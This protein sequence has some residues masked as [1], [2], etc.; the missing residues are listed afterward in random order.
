M[1]CKFIRFEREAQWRSCENRKANMNVPLLKFDIWWP[2]IC[3]ITR[4]FTSLFLMI[5][6][7]AS[8]AMGV[9]RIRSWQNFKCSL[10]EHWKTRAW[11]TSV[12]MYA[13]F[14]WFL[15]IFIAIN[16]SWKGFS[17]EGILESSSSVASQSSVCS[18][19]VGK[20]HTSVKWVIWR[21]QWNV[22]VLVLWYPDSLTAD[23]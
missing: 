10:N 14:L 4:T 18:P 6:I 20:E 2:A 17:A 5:Q 9:R 1:S 13:E 22:F 23:I 16:R 12:A 11:L 15:C 8:A 19:Q 3:E 21:H 7:S